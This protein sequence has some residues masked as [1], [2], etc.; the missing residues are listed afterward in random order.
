MAKKSTTKTEYLR[1]LK[2]GEVLDENN[3]R[4]DNLPYCIFCEQASFEEL[5]RTNGTHLALYLNCS[6]YDVPLHPLLLDGNTE[7]ET[8]EQKWIAYID[9]LADNDKL[10]VGERLATFNDG[11]TQLLRIFGKDFTEKDFGKFVR[12]ETDRI[13]KLIGTQKQRDFWGTI[14]LWQQLEMTAE[15]YN[16]LDRLY[17]GRISRY[18]GVTLDDATID[19]LKNITRW[20]LAQDYMRIRGDVTTIEKLQ[21]VIDSAMASEQ[22]R[23][24]DEKPQ[25]ELRI[26]AL[27]TAL[28]KKGLMENGQLLTYDELVVALR[29]KLVKSKKY[30]YSLDVCD[31]VI[32]DMYNTMRANQDLPKAIDLPAELQPVDEYGEFEAEE[33]EQEKENKRFAGLTKVNFEKPSKKGGK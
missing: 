28:E 4:A 30:R 7:F 29:D 12:F 13:S 9:L 10:Y 31:Q 5:E 16:E 20:S 33:T 26:D 3:C 2:C 1:C 23:R 6:R 11:E 8:A 21:K 32:L 24:K 25:E 15:M 22:L 18:K 17:E 27:V 14:P 19:T